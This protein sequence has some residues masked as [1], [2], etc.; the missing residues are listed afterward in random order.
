MKPLNGVLPKYAPEHCLPAHDLIHFLKDPPTTDPVPGAWAKAK[1]ALRA[2]DVT[3]Q[4]TPAYAEDRVILL[5][6]SDPDLIGLHPY[7]N[8]YLSILAEVDEF[9]VKPHG[10]DA[11]GY[12]VLFDCNYR[13][14]YLL[15]TKTGAREG[16]AIIANGKHPGQAI[17]YQTQTVL[18]E[19][20][21][22]AF[23][24]ATIMGII[25]KDEAAGMEVSARPFEPSDL[26][27]FTRDSC[28]DCGAPIQWVPLQDLPKCR[29]DA[30]EE[31]LHVI[32]DAQ[33]WVCTQCQTFGLASM[34]DFEALMLAA[35]Q[36]TEGVEDV[37][38]A[39]PQ[40]GGATD[41][42]DPASVACTHRE[43]F[44]AQKKAWGAH[45]LLEHGAAFVCRDCGA[46]E[47][48]LLEN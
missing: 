44:L 41:C 14:Q 40:C 33:A 27:H 7:A 13:D 18:S 39:C 48:I 9:L 31:A 8:V 26:E 46:V 23:V 24:R 11:P 22:H 17:R 5:A 30:G 43:Q 20:D 4:G 1:K 28:S 34:G 38:D 2:P 25:D 21:T 45:V 32:P 12:F 36:T 29:P 6:V 37:E 47:F 16:A 19:T 15:T 35:D 10:G 3:I 42:V